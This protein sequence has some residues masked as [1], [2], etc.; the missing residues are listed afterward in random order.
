MCITF[1]HIFVSVLLPNVF[2]GDQIWVWWTSH[3]PS[4]KPCVFTSAK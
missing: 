4:L 3:D 2:E 1:I